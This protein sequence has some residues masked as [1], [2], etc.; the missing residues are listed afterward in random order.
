[1][2]IQQLYKLYIHDVYRYL[3]SLCKDK[4]LAEDLTQDTF[5]K[6]YTAL[7]NIPPKAMKSWLLKIA[8]HTFIDY[9]RRSK[10]V[11]FEEPEYFTGMTEGRSAEDE[12]Q[13]IAAKEELH[14]KLDKL[15]SL[16]RQAIILC[17]I[18]GYSYKEAAGIMGVKENTLKSHIFRGRSRL[19]L[20][21]KKGSGME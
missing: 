11:T 16:Q 7:G 13:E 1:M 15:K 17:D 5:M 20:L 4:G 19:K 9:M 18:Q 6:A 12:Y 10:K 3:L 2:D 8:Y 14:Q 21:Y